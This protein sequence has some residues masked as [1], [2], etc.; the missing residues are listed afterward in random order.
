MAVSNRRLFYIYFMTIRGLYNKIAAIDIDQIAIDSVTETAAEIRHFQLKQL[1]DGKNNTGSD[2]SSY[3]TDP[4]FKT[5]EAARAYSRWKDEIS[6]KTARKSGIKNY[7]INGYFHNSI[8]VKVVG[9]KVVTES[10]TDIGRDIE[11]K[12][13]G[14]Y[15]MSPQSRSEYIPKVLRPRFISK[16]A[17]ATGLKFK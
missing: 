15:G 2:L 1:L 13:P 12:E 6:P 11:A 8:I 4:F 17:L 10:N 3:L 9:D 5:P 16:M 7:Y 14:L